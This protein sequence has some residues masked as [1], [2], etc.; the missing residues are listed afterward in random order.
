MAEPYHI[1]RKLLA[2]N[3]SRQVSSSSFF[4]PASKVCLYV[5]AC[6]SGVEYTFAGGEFEGSGV[7]CP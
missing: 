7:R 4:F 3:S 6:F 2:E 5:C 1:F